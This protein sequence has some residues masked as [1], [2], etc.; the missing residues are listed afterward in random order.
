MSENILVDP[1]T[2]DEETLAQIPGVGKEMAK[3]ILNARPYASLE[4]LIRRWLRSPCHL[5]RA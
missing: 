4:D 5:K 3:R 1:N 2:T